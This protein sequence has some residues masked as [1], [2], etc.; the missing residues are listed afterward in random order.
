MNSTPSQID[1]VLL[2]VRKAY[3]LLHDYQRM[4]L[5]SIRYIG[6]QLDIPYNAGWSKFAG[7]THSG[8]TKLIQWSWDWLPMICY[9][10]HFLKLLGNNEFLSLSF[11]V[12][13]DTGFIE[14]DDTAN[15]RTIISAF[16]P[17]EKS[18]TKFAFILRRTHW[19]PLEFMA[20]KVKMRDFIKEHGKLPDTLV[21][22]G[23]VG[24]C[25]DLSCLASEDQANQIVNDIVA[26]A[27]LKA[28]PLKR[29]K[30]LQ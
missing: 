9:E 1:E 14:G 4:V 18:A 10:F 8:F 3:R 16:A 12:I 21:A 20:D 5:D 29:V 19:N 11:L 15:D 2:D 26:L 27:E 25:Y 23:F 28:F 6:S 13:S 17:A 7:E 24:R 30:K 22:A